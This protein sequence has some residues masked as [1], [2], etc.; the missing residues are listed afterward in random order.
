MLSGTA[1]AVILD[2]GGVDQ[3]GSDGIGRILSLH[4]ALQGRGASL[5]IVNVQPRVRDVFAMANMG[6]LLG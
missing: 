5:A 6:S 4:R 3:V 2:L 1:T